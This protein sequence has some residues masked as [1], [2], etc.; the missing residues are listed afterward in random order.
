MMDRGG[1][2]KA[3]V[4]R[5]DKLGAIVLMIEPGIATDQLDADLKGWLAEAPIQ[6][7][8][9]LP[10]LDVE[11]AIEEMS[12][13]EWRENNRVRV[14]NLYTAARALYDLVAGPGRFLISATRL[15]G[16]H[17]YGETGATAPL[18]GAVV[19][20]TKAYNIEQGMR[21]TGQGVLVKAVDFGVSRKTADPA[22]QLIAETFF[23]PGVVE[24]GYHNGLRYTVTLV[25]KPARDG[26]PGMVLGKDSVF[27]ITGAAGGITSAIT[28]DLAVASSGVFYLLDLVPCPARR[29]REC[30]P[31]PHRQG[32]PQA[33]VD[34]RSPGQGREADPGDS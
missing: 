30:A 14:K 25:E 33:Q 3:L 17:G 4:N 19:G 21:D 6:G 22:D 12:L 5:L 29:R 1:V 16:L 2:G 27:V 8:Y 23:D 10:A 13:E 18:G 7:I 28:T 34:R 9:W 20:F 32:S 31:V 24:V 26:Q 15:G 11:P